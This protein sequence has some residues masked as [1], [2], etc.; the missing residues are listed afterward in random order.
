MSE[1]LEDMAAPLHRSIT[2]K[3]LLAGVP[4]EIAILNGT[5]GAA[6]G[7]GMGSYWVVPVFIGI[8]LLSVRLT[9]ADPQFFDVF[10][11]FIN[12]KDIYEA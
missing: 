4:R 10:K 6:F 8:H 1:E 7:L 5:I 3:I 11:R 2:E 9:K 12:H